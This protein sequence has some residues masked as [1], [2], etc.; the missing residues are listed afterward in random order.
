MFSETRFNL[1]LNPITYGFLRFRQLSGGGAFWPVPRK[2]G[3]SYRID[4]KFATNNGTDDT[5]KHA[6]FKVIGCSTFRAT[7]S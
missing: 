5:S 4:L 1:L 7:T 2:Q 6:K 3:Y